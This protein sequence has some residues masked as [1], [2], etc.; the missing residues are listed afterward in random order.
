MQ[1]MVSLSTN[2]M[3]LN[4]SLVQNNGLS[5]YQSDLLNTTAKINAHPVNWLA[6]IYE[7]TFGKEL[8]KFK[9]IDIKS[10]STSVSQRLTCNLNISKSWVFKLFGEHYSNQI[11]ENRHKQLFIA[12]ISTAY[13]FKSG[14]ELSLNIRNLFNQKTYAYTAYSSLTQIHQQYE[15]RTRNIWASVFFHF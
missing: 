5:N 15:L 7:L 12:D 11:S 13:S 3:S 9:E 1:G 2:Y 14:V 8:M 10:A 4:G 6:I